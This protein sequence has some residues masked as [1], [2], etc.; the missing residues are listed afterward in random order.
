M[1]VGNTTGV[2]AAISGDAVS[3]RYFNKQGI[4]VIPGNE[5]AALVKVTTYSNGKT[6]AEKV[7]E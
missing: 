7:I 4:E 6:K 1:T 5:P 2:E 3:V